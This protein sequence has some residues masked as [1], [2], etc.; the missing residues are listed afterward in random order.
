MDPKFSKWSLPCCCIREIGA[1]RT[2]VRDEVRLQNGRPLVVGKV[3]VEA[4]QLELLGKA[5]PEQTNDLVWYRRP[6]EDLAKIV[7]LVRHKE[8]TGESPLRVHSVKEMRKKAYIPLDKH[9][10]LIQH[11]SAVFCHKRVPADWQ[12]LDR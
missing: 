3:L 12:P 11:G 5:V 7:D 8:L 10:S 9:T 2:T 6:S 1:Q 4:F